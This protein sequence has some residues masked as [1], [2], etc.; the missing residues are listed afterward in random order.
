MNIGTPRFQSLLEEAAATNALHLPFLGLDR[1]PSEVFKLT[2]LIR[3][4]LGQ[5]N[6]SELPEAI[7][8]L[9][10][11]VAQGGAATAFRYRFAMQT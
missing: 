2:S 1:V 3:L 4:D 11:Y 8:D 10:A 7:G 5:N 6:I 9:K